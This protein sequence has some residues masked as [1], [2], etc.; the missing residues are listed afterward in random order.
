MNNKQCLKCKA[1]SL[2]FP[3]QVLVILT[4]FCNQ[5]CIKKVVKSWITKN[6]LKSIVS[7]FTSFAGAPSKLKGKNIVGY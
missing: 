4:C 1:N 2:D 3:N 7:D 6:K 5:L